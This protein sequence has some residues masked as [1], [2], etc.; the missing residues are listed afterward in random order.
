MGTEIPFLI[1]H[2]R[3]LTEEILQLPCSY[4]DVCVE[5]I[6]QY[7]QSHR[8]Y[9]N[10]QHIKECLIA[11]DRLMGSQYYN[12]RSMGIVNLAIW[13]HDVVYDSRKDDNEENSALFFY[14]KMKA[15]LKSSDCLKIAS[16]IQGT[17][18]HESSPNPYQNYVNDIDLHILGTDDMGRLEEY[19]QQIRQE[20]SW[21]PL[22]EYKTARISVLEHILSRSSI[23]H[24]EYFYQ[25]MEI[26]A[27]ENLEWLIQKN[28]EIV[29]T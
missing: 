7:S 23:F 29:Q 9:H 11:L 24:S 8:Y 15:I 27:R 28:K 22:A 6:G 5:V 2:W 3:Y 17:K 4:L 18:T 12:A 20:Y 21:V 10:L 1:D 16:L 26:Q 19:D 25:N 13:F 14:K